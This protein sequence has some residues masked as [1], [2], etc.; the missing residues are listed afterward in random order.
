MDSAAAASPLA[1]AVAAAGLGPKWKW[2][3]STRRSESAAAPGKDRLDPELTAA[4][5]AAAGAAMAAADAAGLRTAS[6]PCCAGGVS[7]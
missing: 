1:D 7:E 2:R 6:G 3:G 4:A 5:P